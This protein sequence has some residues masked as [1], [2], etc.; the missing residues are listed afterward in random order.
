[1]AMTPKR[2]RSIYWI[3]MQWGWRGPAVVL[4]LVIFLYLY[5]WGWM[6]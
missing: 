6:Y 3:I 2:R 5:Y 4:I 1:M